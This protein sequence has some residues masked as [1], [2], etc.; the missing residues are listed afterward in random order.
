MRN[1]LTTS[2]ALIALAF[3]T[4]SIAQ[5]KVLGLAAIDL[6]NSF[7]VRMKE[8]GDVAASDYGVKSTWQSAE[9]SL[10]KQVGIIENFI[11]QGVSAILVDPIDKN[12]VVPVIKKATAAGIPVITMGNKVEAGEN[13][14]TL[15]PDYENMGMVARA[16]GTTLGGKG[17]IALLVGSRG[18]FVSDTREKGFV[19]VMAKEFP[20]IKIVGIEPTGWDAAKATNA[21][22]TWLTTYPDLKAIACI[23]DS[24]CLAADSVA[25]AM[26]SDLIYGG[27]DGD[28]E[29]KDMIDSGKMVMDVLTGAY[30][31]GY[32]NVAV[33]ARLANGEDLPKDL[34]MPTYFV[35]SD[36]T[37]AKLK[38]AGLEFDS[39]NTE[40]EAVEAENYTEQLGPKQPSSAMTVGD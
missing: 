2:V 25:T 10:E 9:G 35:T 7:Y 8:A 4:P 28:A 32:W 6:Q 39:L 16:V 30:R 11:N 26:G 27:Y 37:A 36:E 13:Y 1:I 17:E 19:D 3:A 20:D 40:E 31:V 33:A 15:Y 5:E 12:A 23:S 38:E 29:M 18:N 21:A 24:L 34:Y 22:Q 14:S